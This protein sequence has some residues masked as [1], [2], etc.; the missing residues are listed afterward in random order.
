MRKI[1]LP[2]ALF[3][4]V[5]SQ[6]A[7]AQTTS[8]EQKVTACTKQYD[9]FLRKEV[10]AYVDKEPQ[11]PGGMNAFTLYIAKNFTYPD[12]DDPQS[13]FL[14]EFIINTEGK[15]IVT[16]INKK[17]KADMTNAE[18]A[19]LKILEKTPKW[20]PGECSGKKVPVWIAMP[21]RRCRIND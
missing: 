16:R 2:I 7:H 4:I 17:Q 20:K 13:T 8:Q 15:I 1:F 9:P 21:L 5:T 3:F 11:Y 6:S 14:V 12:K 18:K 19:L 10:Y